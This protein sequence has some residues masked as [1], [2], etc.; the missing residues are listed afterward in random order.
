M[1]RELL[2]LFY[3]RIC[4]GCGRLLLHAEQHLCTA[5]LVGLPKTNQHL[6]HEN[7]VEKVFWG[8]VNINHASAFLHFKKEGVTQ[9]ILHELKYKGNTSLAEMMG[10]MYASDL[11]STLHQ[12][13]YIIPVPLHKKKLKERGYNQSACF[14]K[15]LSVV[16]KVPML[17][18][19]ILKVT[20]TSTQ[21]KKSRFERWKNVEEVFAVPD[22]SVF[23][24]KHILICDDVITTGATIEA[25]IKKLPSSTKVS[26]CSIAFADKGL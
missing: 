22:M 24:N 13:D 4:C 11:M 19:G 8:R 5:C 2:E 25:L 14:G 21:T 9:H 16:M 18:D 7:V 15:G 10:R 20:S 12:L 6:K 3:P 26:I 17:E 1:L 23:E